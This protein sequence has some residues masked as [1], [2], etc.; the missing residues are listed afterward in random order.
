MVISPSTRRNARP[1]LAGR[2]RRRQTRGLAKPRGKRTAWTPAPVVWSACRALSLRLDARATQTANR[3]EDEVPDRK[4]PRVR[5][6]K[7]L[8]SRSSDARAPQ[9]ASRA[10]G[11]ARTRS[12]L[13]MRTR[14]RTRLRCRT[15]IGSGRRSSAMLRSAWIREETMT[16]RAAKAA[17]ISVAARAAS[18]EKAMSRRRSSI[19]G[20]ARS[21]R[22]KARLTPANAPCLRRISR[23]A[24]RTRL[25]HR[26]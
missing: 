9:A 11:A 14:E 3:I 26:S 12:L 13:P 19:Y 7:R 6:S 16:T 24:I 15:G 10:P 20:T 23:S 17:R 18:W 1:P 21:R 4:A 22:P 5:D 25:G 8:R 2:R